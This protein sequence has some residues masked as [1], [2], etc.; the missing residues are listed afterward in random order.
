MPA[1]A[2][3]AKARAHIVDTGIGSVVRDY[4]QGDVLA[5]AAYMEEEMGL[6]TRINKD[7]IRTTNL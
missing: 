1:V 6:E 7:M 2:A 3:T 4:G 5:T